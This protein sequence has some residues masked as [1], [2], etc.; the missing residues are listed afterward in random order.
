MHVTHRP[1]LARAPEA[2]EFLK[3]GG[4][5]G[6]EIAGAVEVVSCPQIAYAGTA[7]KRLSSNKA[8]V[9]V[10]PA[11]AAV[12]GFYR[13]SAAP[14]CTSRSAPDVW[15]SSRRHYSVPTGSDDVR[16]LKAV[17]ELSTIF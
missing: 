14:G 3:I 8:F 1:L 17:N 6:L 16:N 9:V 4:P 15:A 10:H 12:S 5:Q 7:R 13:P 2:G 11:P